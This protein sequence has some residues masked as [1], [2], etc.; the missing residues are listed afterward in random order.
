MFTVDNNRN[1]EKSLFFMREMGSFTDSVLFHY[2]D[3]NN[4]LFFILHDAGKKHLPF[5]F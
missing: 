5:H 3:Q 1:A 4:K 2:A